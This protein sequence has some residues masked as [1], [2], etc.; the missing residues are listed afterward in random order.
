MSDYLMRSQAPLTPVEWQAFDDAVVQVARRTLVARRFLTVVGPLGPGVQSFAAD[1]YLAEEKGR[2]SLLGSEE[3]DIVQVNSRRLASLPIL[4]RDFSLNWRDLESARLQA[5]PLDTTAPSVA[6]SAV[7]S[8]EDQ[9]IFNGYDELGQEGFLNATGRLRVPLGDWDAA[10]GG[11]AAVSNAL[12]ALVEHHFRGPFALA[13]PPQLFVLLN[14]VFGNTG[15]LEIDQVKR[16]VGG[17]VY[18]T[19]ALPAN[20][21]VLV[22]PGPENMDLLISQDLTIAFLESTAMQHHFRVLEIVALRVK[23]PGAICV[24]GQA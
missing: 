20:T 6:A 14:R 4:Y 18:V 15:V 17:G 5:M 23:R 21:A 24:L 9:L 16:L 12:R 8:S 2:I 22:A 19:P 1:T 11:F 13:V 7:T 10:G 3:T